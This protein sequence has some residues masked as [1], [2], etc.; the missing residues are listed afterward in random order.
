MNS[1]DNAPSAGELHF[2]LAACDHLL[3]HDKLNVGELCKTGATL[4]RLNRPVESR[5]CY[6]AAVEALHHAIKIDHVEAALSFETLIHRA[7]VST[8]EDEQHYYR[9]YND[10]R[11]EMAKFGR[12]YRRASP[13]P[14]NPRNIAFVLASGSLLG[15]TEV[16]FNI[17]REASVLQSLGITAR[18]Y[19]LYDSYAPFLER[20]AKDGH[21][22]YIAEKE[23]P[24]GWHAT[25]LER[26]EWLR[27]RVREHDCG[28]A[29]WVTN[30]SGAIFMLSA[31]IA[32]VQIFWSLRFHPI[33]GPF[34][35]GYISYGPR[36][37]REKVIGKTAWQVCPVPLA[38]EPRERDEQA[39][40]ELRRRFPQRVLAGTLART[41]K[42]DSKPFLES[43]ARI[44]R[45]NPDLGYLWT[46]RNRHP[47]IQ[48]FF[49]SAGLAER[50]HFVGWVDT[51]L[52]AQ[53]LDIFLET[54]PTGCGITGYQALAAG[55]PLLS[56]REQNTIFGLQ[57]GVSDRE[58]AR[59]AVPGPILA[60]R[61]P[62]E[63]VA[64]ANRLV[65]DPAFREEV[66]TRGR[67][68]F[69]AEVND[70]EYYARRFL[71]TVLAIADKTLAAKSPNAPATVAR[72]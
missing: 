11:S 65:A 60:A 28:V 53:A 20:V 4:Q 70:G 5:K 46:G 67:A 40:A 39:I 62:D 9:C 26:L 33:S 44:L 37:Q 43:V 31:G 16:M 12:R 17:L 52:Y 24:Q 54:F 61:D 57:F 30:A 42:I 69:E 72:T 32:S 14:T 25:E 38:L 3:R 15:H 21:S 2:A 59:T 22:L 45:E 63:Y 34:I 8:T 50:C 23:L 10:W 51:V 35:D 27:A 6:K 49:E 13:M 29:I 56:Y 19:V 55:T 41:E 7:F 48:Q 36:H 18:I 68:F 71:E 58:E 64:L 47:G 1:T 66:G